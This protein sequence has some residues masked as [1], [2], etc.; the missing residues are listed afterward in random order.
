MRHRFFHLLDRHDCP[1]HGH[2]FYGLA[3]RPD[4]ER[5]FAGRGRHFGGPGGFEGPFGPQRS[6]MFNSGDLKLVLLKLL[7]E[8]PSYGYQLIKSL[9][10]RLGGGYV[11]SAGAIYPTL[12]LLEE[13]GSATSVTENNKKV[14]SI[15]PQGLETLKANESHLEELF[16][17]LDEKG[18]R[19]GR[20]RS[21]E[22]MKAFF[23]LRSAVGARIS[24]DKMSKEQIHKMA[25]AINA[26]AKT[27]DEL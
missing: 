13:E 1:E 17:H 4:F 10:E 16:S 23:N 24:R 26:A 5:M 21:P 22:L 9:E 18:R 19:F 2:P 20:G 8:Q 3:A 12:T 15:T 11:P 25:E 6:R 14:Y 27:I 7:A